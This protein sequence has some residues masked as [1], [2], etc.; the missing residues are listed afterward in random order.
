MDT[1]KTNEEL[2][3][4]ISQ[5]QEEISR[6]KI[7]IQNLPGCIYWKNKDG[8]YLGRNLY[9][10]ENMR[11]HGM[12][13]QTV[14]DS[15]I[16]KTDYDFFSQKTADYFRKHDLEVMNTGKEISVEE[17]IHLPDGRTI[18]QLS[19]KRPMTDSSG[20]IIGIIGNTVDITHLKRAETQ[21]RIAREKAEA[22]NQAK[23]EFLHN[24]KHDLRTPFSGILGIAEL[25]AASESDTEKKENL[26]AIAQSARVLLNHLNEIFE[27]IQ[28][29]NGHLP[30]L[31]KPF[32]LKI[33]LDD[34]KKIMLP[35]AKN[36]GIIFSIKKKK[37]LVKK[38]IGDRVR[39][40]RILMNLISNSIKF[41]KQGK[42]TLTVEMS[43][44][45][46]NKIIMIFTL[47]DTGIG[48]A[49]DHQNIIFEQ[50]NRL[51]S[52][53]SSAYPGKGLGLRMVKIFLDEL[54]GEATL[55]STLGQGTTFKI[56]I[57]Y[58]VPLKNTLEMKRTMEK[59]EP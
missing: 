19:T 28:F 35:A 25:M 29:E 7:I 47:Q 52:S 30:I 24:M 17:P 3:S 1:K 9:S 59:D 11:S 27:F 21:L 40:Q 49:T 14:V 18:V 39:T 44:L 16:G 55:K 50:F 5:Q 36:K 31:E 10:A 43:K 22:S 48:I 2:K 32:D 6:L 33:L 41:T 26:S 20:N 56:L 51:T 4:I 8:V 53:Y 54:N 34:I 45:S 23:T 15:V 38:L 37:V 57:P 42:V 58:K 12:E 46:E 13:E